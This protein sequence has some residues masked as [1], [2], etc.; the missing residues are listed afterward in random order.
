MTHH[1][2]SVPDCERAP[3]WRDAAACRNYNPELFFPVGNTGSALLQ[4]EEAKAV[5]YRCPAIEWC[6]RW[7]LDT[8]QESG[9][10]GGLS[11]DER[12]ALKRR[13]ARQSGRE[14]VDMLV[15]NKTASLEDACRELYDRYTELRGEHLVWIAERTQVKIRHRERTYGQICFQAAHGRWPDGPVYRTC[16]VDQ[17]VA[18]R[19]LTDKTIRASRKAIA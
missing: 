13:A 12:R 6:L 8:G 18:P 14:P 2:G 17:C 5:C 19:C 3:D 7:A 11:E 1:T 15:F 16:D 9:V 4:I 10:W